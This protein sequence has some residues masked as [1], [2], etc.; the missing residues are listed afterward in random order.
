MEDASLR[1]GSKVSYLAVPGPA[2]AANATSF[3]GS[4]LVRNCGVIV[5]LGAPEQAAVITDAPR[6]PAVRFVI[7]GGGMAGPVGGANLAVVSSAPS[8]LRSAV[9]AMVVA[10]VDR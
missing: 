8:G 4:L 1:T 10:D 5:A 7:A 2:T 3:V 9:R 6:F